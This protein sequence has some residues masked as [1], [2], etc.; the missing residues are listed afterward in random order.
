MEGKGRVGVKDE[1]KI[2]GFKLGGRW[3]DLLRRN[4]GD[5]REREI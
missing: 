5:L 3:Y 2:F 1:F 4:I